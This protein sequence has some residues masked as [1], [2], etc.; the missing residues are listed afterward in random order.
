MGHNK[1]KTEAFVNYSI[2]KGLVVSVETIGPIS[3]DHSL[4]EN[5]DYYLMQDG[6]YEKNT[7]SLKK[8]EDGSLNL[9]DQLKQKTS[10]VSHEQMTKEITDFELHQKNS[11]VTS[12]IREPN[13]EVS[14]KTFCDALQKSETLLHAKALTKHG[15]S[16]SSGTTNIGSYGIQ[17]GQTTDQL[18]R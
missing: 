9:N 2:H 10:I 3:K 16:I 5:N 11:G 4:Y 8:R 15:T 17:S 13:I 14:Y 12:S 1:K 6:N 18:K 7:Y